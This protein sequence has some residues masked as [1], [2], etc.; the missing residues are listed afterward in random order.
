MRQAGDPEGKFNVFVS[1]HKQELAPTAPSPR[2]LTQPCLTA[3]LPPQNP[4]RMRA[5]THSTGLGTVS[6]GCAPSPAQ[7]T[8]PFPVSAWHELTP[9]PLTHNLLCGIFPRQRGKVKMGE[10]LAGK[11]RL[12]L[13]PAAAAGDCTS[14]ACLGRDGGLQDRAVLLPAMREKSRAQLSATGLNAR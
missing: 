6:Q 5:A 1:P 8:E 7:Q 12:P 10:G 3:P 9:S 14:K 2:A 4:G 11:H 13:P